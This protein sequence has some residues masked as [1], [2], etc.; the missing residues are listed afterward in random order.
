MTSL[1]PIP[2]TLS[3]HLRQLGLPQTAADLNDLIARATQKRWSP[4]VLLD[5]V[6]RAELDGPVAAVVDGT[7]HEA[8]R[9]QQGQDV[10]QRIH[11]DFGRLRRY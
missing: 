9:P 10:G 11:G 4:A 3:D 7:R 8:T 2:T 1:D 6:V 5:T